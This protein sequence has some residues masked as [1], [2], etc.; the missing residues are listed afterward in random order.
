[1]T[2]KPITL[3]FYDSNDQVK[4]TH[5][6]SRIPWGV[7]KRAIR[8]ASTIDTAE[9]GED[10]L[11]EMASLLVDAFGGAFTV[12]DIDKYCDIND[13]MVAIQGIIDKASATVPNPKP[14]A[15]K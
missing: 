15:Q 12:E 14:P 7:L 6:R 13:V 2:P 4:A 10:A 3:I 5:T 9:I 8:M 11:D 1:M